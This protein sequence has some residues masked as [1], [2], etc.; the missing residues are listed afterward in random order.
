[1]R[2]VW[3]TDP[4]LNHVPLGPWERWLEILHSLAPDALILTGDIS[5]GEDV[6]FQLQRLAEAVAVP[7][8][9]V[10][11]NHDFYQS[12][13][14]GTRRR[15]VELGREHRLLNY[16]TDSAAVD[17]G[18]G[19][20]LV[21]DDGWGDAVEGDYEGSI[22]QLNDFR[23]IEDF[24]QSDPRRWKTL[25]Q[26]QGEASAARL[27]EKLRQLPAS[28][29]H[30]IV[31]THVP[32][33]REA[34]WYEGRTTDDHWAPFF[35]CGS[36]GRVLRS[37]SEARPE[38]HF[39]V[40]CGHTH[41]GGVAELAANLTVYTGAAEYGHPAAQGWIEAAGELRVLTR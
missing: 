17:C 9:F 22:V 20:Y 31:A 13:I 8:H 27:E 29:R 32:P 10:L 40:L 37:A 30:V 28:A 15:I 36:V 2:F 35:V 3:T 12:S 1:M 33:F 34:C 7:V 6:A 11:G 23:L 14:G 41:H 38:C 25:L 24:R 18:T 16:L 21:G 19:I 26:Q 5:E 39:T 4:H